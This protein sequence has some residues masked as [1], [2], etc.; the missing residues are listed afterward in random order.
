MAGLVA[1][2]ANSELNITIASNAVML[3]G[4]VAT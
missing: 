1:A 4:E 2:N 3:P